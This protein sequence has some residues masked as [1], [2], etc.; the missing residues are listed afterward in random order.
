MNTYKDSPLVWVRFDY[1]LSKTIA[2]FLFRYLSNILNLALIVIMTL[3]SE[4]ASVS[5]GGRPFFLLFYLSLALDACVF[6]WF[7]FK[8]FREAANFGSI[9]YTVI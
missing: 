4:S 5:H 9:H 6:A 8:S 2:T 3:N 7:A 1:K